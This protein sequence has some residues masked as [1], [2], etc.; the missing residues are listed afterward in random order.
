[1]I[2]I[3]NFKK[4]Y[5]D[6]TTV[7]YDQ[8]DFASNGIYHFK[9]DNGTGKSTFFNCITGVDSSYEAEILF[10]N[11]LKSKSYCANKICY[12]M[13]DVHLI[14]NLTGLQQLL[15]M[16][17]IEEVNYSDSFIKNILI[18]L[19]LDK[20]INE[21]ISTYSVGQK[22]KLEFIR[23]LI[24]KKSIIILDEPFSQ[25]DQN[26]IESMISYLYSLSSS[27]LIVY[28]NHEKI[29]KKTFIPEIISLKKKSSPLWL[30][31]LFFKRNIILM[32]IS[33]IILIFGNVLYMYFST[34][35]H[36]NQK[37]I[38]NDFY[39]SVQYAIFETDEPTSN[40]T[41]NEGLYSSMSEI[42]YESYNTSMLVTSELNKLP[43]LEGSYPSSTSEILIGYSQIKS[44]VDN[45]QI[46]QSNILNKSIY[47]DNES[48]KITGIVDS[49]II[50]DLFTS[51]YEKNVYLSTYPNF[52]GYSNSISEPSI[53]L[54]FRSDISN[55]TVKEKIKN[56]SFSSVFQTE[57]SINNLISPMI[58]NSI[59]IILSIIVYFLGLER[60]KFNRRFT[61][62]LYSLG[63]KKY[64][65]IVTIILLELLLVSICFFSSYHIA[66]Y[67]LNIQNEKIL[68]GFFIQINPF[69]LSQSTLLLIAIPC[70]ISIISLFIN[71][72]ISFN[73]SESSS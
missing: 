9:G 25:I 6:Q 19:D 32:L 53:N 14:E 51:E 48:Y 26:S 37:I 4:V 30:V 33:A 55:L 24:T 41:F 68:K 23:V 40:A 58:I 2:R 69:T 38:V 54:L 45:Y 49:P 3:K 1:M 66:N 73:E 20:I 28:S 21:T 13:Q 42:N 10:N 62:S 61:T 47:I 18:K 34:V 39:D 7:V 35:N 65:I 71:Q 46:S 64:R 15:I 57:L 52:F 56:G 17:K 63:V 29:V 43:L 22:R 67:F 8:L 5:D 59:L 50:K 44:M 72:L 27:K 16:H 12:M 36:Y 31:T 60:S 11:N 70:S